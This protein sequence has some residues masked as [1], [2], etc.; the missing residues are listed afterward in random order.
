MRELMKRFPK[1]EQAEIARRMLQR[2]DEELRRT[3]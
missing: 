3:P 2:F 1:T